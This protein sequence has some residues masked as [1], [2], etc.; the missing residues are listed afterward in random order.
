M[1]MKQWLLAVGILVATLGVSG[2]A[3]AQY[4]YTPMVPCRAVDTRIAGFQGVNGTPKVGPAGRTFQIRGKCGVPSTA[5]AVSVT[6][7]ATTLT[8]A[9]FSALWP[10][11]IVYPQ[12]SNIN[13]IAV[14]GAVANGAVVMLGP[15]TAALDL[16]AIASGVGVDLIIDVVGYYK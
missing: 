9:G 14:D 10:A 6:V 16:N 7:T 15:N 5:Q 11:G 4:T 3:A 8:E 13:Y 2:T 12:H 1:K